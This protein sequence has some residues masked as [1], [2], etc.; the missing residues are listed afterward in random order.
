MPENPVQPPSISDPKTSPGVPW[1]ESTSFWGAVGV[2]LTVVGAMRHDLL[3]LLWFAWACFVIRLWSGTS[4][5]KRHR[6]LSFVGGFVLISVAFFMLKTWLS[7]APPT[8]AAPASPAPNPGPVSGPQGSVSRTIPPKPAQF[9]PHKP[10]PQLAAKTAVPPGSPA[11]AGPA[12]PPPA[13]F[14][15]QGN[16]GNVAGINNGTQTFNQYGQPQPPPNITVTSVEAA[17]MKAMD[18]EIDPSLG[19]HPGTIIAFV[20]DRVFAES[21]IFEVACD[22]PCKATGFSAIGS[23]SPRTFNTSNPLVSAIGLGNIHALAPGD[24]ISITV[25]SLDAQAIRVKS[26]AFY[27]PPLGN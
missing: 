20:I 23:F 3:W 1:Y 8:V 25:R 15:I 5:L 21:A 2:V 9:P 16:T 18:D 22:R 6:A 24:R 4:R 14:N 12:N 17:P 26:L 7:Y 11:S 27:M 13:T 10:K 19:M